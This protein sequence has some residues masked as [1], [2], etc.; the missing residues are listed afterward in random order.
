MQRECFFYRSDKNP[1]LTVADMPFSAAAV[2]NP[3]ATLQDDKVVL[4]LRVEDYSGRSNI[5]VARSDDG[6]ANWE[7][8]AEPILRSGHTDHGYESWGCED[9]RVVYLPNQQAWYI[10]YTA[11]S[12]YGAAVALAKSKDLMTAERIGLILPPNN[13]DAALF[14]HRVNDHYVALHRPDAGGGIEDIW[15][16]FSPDL[17]HWGR[18]YCVLREGAGAAWDAQRVGAGP[19]PILTEEGWL[20]IYHG[21]KQYGLNL[22]YRAGIALLDREHPEVLIG[23]SPGW[24]FQAEEMYEVSGFVPGVVFPTGLVQRDDELFMYYGAADTCVCLAQAKLKD[25]LNAVSPA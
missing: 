5:H 23:R 14:P 24:V 16:A 17:I 12:K 2:L 21:V 10:T 4:L 13:K 11:F 9:A 18:P 8:E 6:I 1:I 3:G 15:I 22:N 19:P 7:V 25:V 20:L